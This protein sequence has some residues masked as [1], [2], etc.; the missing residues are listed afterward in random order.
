MK[1]KIPNYRKLLLI[2]YGNVQVLPQ[3][4]QEFDWDEDKVLVRV[5]FSAIS[6]GTEYA[7]VAGDPNIDATRKVEDTLQPLPRGLGYTCSGIVENVGANIADLIVGDR[8]VIRGGGHAS[9]HV[10]PRDQIYRLPYEEITLEEIAPAYIATFSLSG[11][12]KIRVEAGE[13]AAVMGCGILGLFAVQFLSA[14]GA[15]PVIAVDPVA[16]KREKALSLGADYALDP[17]DPNFVQNVLDLTDG[18]GINA[19]V[20][21]TGKG[22]GLDMLLDIMARHG[23]ISL[24]GCTRHSDFTIDYYRKIHY[25]GIEL[26]GAHT[27]TR[28]DNDSRPG[29]WAYKD[30]YPAIF[31]L[32]HHNKVNFKAMIS[33]IH[34]AGE[35]HD[36]YNRLATDY[37]HFP[38]GVLLDW[39][40]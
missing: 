25:P 28:P 30:E 34:P 3:P 13:S 39:R 19:A 29:F 11:A 21:V 2:D 38:I 22:Q 14:M 18:R 8:V 7:H 4:E 31:R 23:R 26:L 17:F 40:S 33:E 9:H 10:L 15:T 24:L 35:A 37:A 5:H 6:A 16:E 32:I 12:R 36:V 20:E 27:G 1:I